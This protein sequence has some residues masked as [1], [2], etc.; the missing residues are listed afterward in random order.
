MKLAFLVYHD[1]LEDRVV[2]ILDELKIKTYSEWEKVTGRLFSDAEPH[3]GTRTFPGHDIV[4]LIPFEEEGGLEPLI[5][6]IREFN[7]RAVKKDDEVRMFL[8][9]LEKIV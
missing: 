3:L 5:T 6:T 8:L 2:E 9:P 4:R 1:I 7:K